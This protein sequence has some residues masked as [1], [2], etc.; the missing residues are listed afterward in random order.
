M[1]NYIAAALPALALAACSGGSEALQPGQWEMTLTVTEA[2]A[3]G[4]P[5]GEEAGMIAELNRELA[6]DPSCVSEEQAAS[7]TY[8]IFVPREAASEC[9][10]S[11]STV[12]NGVIQIAGACGDGPDEGGELTLTG[13]YSATSMEGVMTAQ[14]QDGRR[15]FSFNAT[16]TGER[17]GE[18]SG[19]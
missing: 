9:D 8:N 14:I 5:E 3:E 19:K 6:M 18:C 1:K 16:M 4:M 12:E 7:P 10:F 2:S 15:A 13:T 17:T 11:G